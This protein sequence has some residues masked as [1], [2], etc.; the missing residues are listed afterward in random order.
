MST[1]NRTFLHGKL[2][3]DP[4]LRQTNSNKSVC[5]FR[6]M[7]ID[8]KD[9]E[10]KG[11]AEFHSVTAWGSHAETI[12]TYFKKGDPILIWG[13]NHSSSYEKNGKKVYT[14]EVVEEQFGF[15]LARKSDDERQHTTADAFEDFEEE[16][17]LPF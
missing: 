9:S 1:N 8:G 4:E 6:I 16:G 13:R 7:T 2:T 3:S 10:G 17:E 14:H 15:P 5:R 12:N 11:V